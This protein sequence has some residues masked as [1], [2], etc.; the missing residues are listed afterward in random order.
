MTATPPR[1]GTGT[2]LSYAVG[3]VG[4]QM[5][6]A[7]MSFLLMI[8]YTDVALVPPAIAGAALLV[9]KFWDAVNDPLLGWMSDRTRSRHGR[10]RVYLL[11]GALPLALAAAAVWMVPPGLSPLAAFVWIALTYTLFDTLMTLV[12]LPYSALATELTLD[13]D[14]RTSLT[15]FASMGALLGFVGGSVL[16]P[17]LVRASPDARTGYALAGLCFGVFAGLCVAWVAWRVREPAHCLRPPA[18]HPKMSIAASL[19]RTLQVTLRNRH[20]VLL[21][22]AVGLV[23]LY[24]LQ[25]GQHVAMVALLVLIGLGMGAH[26]IVPFSMVPDTID[27]GHMQAGERTTGMYLGF[28]GLVDKLAR[29]LA[30][31]LIAGMLDW[32]GYVPNVP[33]GDLALQGIA[34]MTGPLPALCLLL[35]IPLLLAYPITRA[36]HATIRQSVDTGIAPP[37]LQS[38]G[39][40]STGPE[41]C[42]TRSATQNGCAQDARAA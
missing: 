15:A 35:A 1:L 24:F 30:T 13:Y 12:Q 29:T 23:A 6:V 9:G 41:G 34:L 11:Y 21:V 17:L 25:P 14:E 33:Q 16:M 32:T 8:F 18:T 3:N 38:G 28:Y 27:H 37:A 36:Q 40:G 42:T 4:L 31:V 20:F 5:L 10:H 22:G 26:W 7:A 39:M 2:K 19:R